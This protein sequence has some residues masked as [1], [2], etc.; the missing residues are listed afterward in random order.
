MTALILLVFF[1]G[2]LGITL[3]HSLKLD[4]LIPA[5]VMMAVC[6]ALVAVGKLVRFQPTCPSRRLQSIHHWRENPPY[7]GDLTASSREDR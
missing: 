6:W 7:G 1:L 4:K 3:E 5:L 2:Y